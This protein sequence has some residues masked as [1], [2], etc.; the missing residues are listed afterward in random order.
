MRAAW[1]QNQALA[2]LLFLPLAAGC[3]HDAVAPEEKPS[4]QVQGETITLSPSS[5]QLTSVSAERVGAIETS[6][7]RFNG[8]LVWD[9][10]STV[11][12]FAPFSGRI[13]KVFVKP[14]QVIAAGTPLAEIIS[15]EYGQAQ[16]EAQKA[17]QDY[18]QAER[19]LERLKQL[20]EH[21]AAPKK[22]LDSAESDF[23]RA[24]S[25][26]QRT[27]ARLAFYGGDSQKLDQAY[28]LRSP[29]AGVVVERNFSAGQEVRA[30]QMMSNV[31]QLAVPIFVVSNPE[32]LWVML[33]VN[34]ESLT[35]VHPG[36]EI[37]IKSRAYG[38]KTFQGHIDWVGDT[39]DATTRTVKVRG[40]VAN[41][42]RLLKSEMYVE[43]SVPQRHASAL[44][45][46]AKAVF[47]KDD[48]H[49]VFVE[50]SPG[51]FLRK[52]VHIGDEQDGQVL[53][54]DGLE[55]GQSVVT[56]GSLLLQ[57]IAESGGRS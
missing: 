37:T 44:H 10:D 26:R 57:Q 40:V 48:K 33:D 49:Y 21:G 55:K 22:D 8:R 46:A 24:T 2:A 47:L 23:A 19:N 5:P 34:E 39:L 12:T 36:Q 4:A 38:D 13:E 28:Q 20:F 17:L 15:P 14:G 18:M 31:P 6:T 43:A 32:S 7:M 30:D 54:L 1:S 9:E 16:S 56:D 51:K 53:V 41:P 25:E 11:R 3:K 45:I 27:T 42:D 29:I 52:E 35:L 50:Q